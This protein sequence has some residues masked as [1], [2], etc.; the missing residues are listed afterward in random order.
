MDRG[1]MKDVPC[2]GE[3]CTHQGYTI[4]LDD[5]WRRCNM[6]GEEWREEANDAG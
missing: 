5:G 3:P 1:W 6:C 2:P 4:H